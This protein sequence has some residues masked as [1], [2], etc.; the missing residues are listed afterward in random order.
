M[1]TEIKQY[2]AVAPTGQG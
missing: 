2:K 1:S